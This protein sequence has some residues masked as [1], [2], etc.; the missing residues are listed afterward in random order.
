MLFLSSEAA[1]KPGGPFLGEFTSG[2]FSQGF[3]L[4]RPSLAYKGCGDSVF[5]TELFVGVIG[6]YRVGSHASYPYTHKL[7]LH[8]DTVLKPY[9]LIECLEREVFDER[10]AVYLYVA[11]LCTELDR[12]CFL[13]PYYGTYIMMVNAYNTVIDFPAFKQFLC[14]Y[15]NLS[16]YGKTLLIIL[17][18]SE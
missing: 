3:I 12:L 4:G 7:L 17:G 9:S 11:N 8:T 2:Y 16:D 6:I 13:T 10:Y 5:R 14:L 1:F 18:I 15:K